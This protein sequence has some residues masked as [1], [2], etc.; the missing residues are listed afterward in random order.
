MC[1]L[2]KHHSAEKFFFR[3]E[4]EHMGLKLS[5]SVFQ[6]NRN[7]RLFKSYAVGASDVM[8]MLNISR[9]ASLFSTHEFFIISAFTPWKFAALPL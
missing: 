9:F 4:M 5:G 2:E 7:H 3:L 1:D 6:H 8:A